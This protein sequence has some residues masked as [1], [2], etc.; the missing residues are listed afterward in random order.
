MHTVA[1]TPDNNIVLTALRSSNR[2]IFIEL[3]DYYSPALFKNIYKL[4]HNTADAED[5]LQSV[6]LTLWEQRTTLSNDQS[7]A[8]W[9]FSTSFYLSMTLLRKKIRARVEALQEEMEAPTQQA[10]LEMEMLYTQRSVFLR[11]AINQLPER[12]RRAFELCRIEGRSYD[13]AANTLGITADTVREYVKSAMK[14]L[15]LMASKTDV[16]LYTCLLLFMA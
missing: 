6:F 15:K 16:S 10:F 3:Y 8:G 7:V 1:I 4:L 9:L 5:V 13:E 11:E 12:K 14:T 2:K